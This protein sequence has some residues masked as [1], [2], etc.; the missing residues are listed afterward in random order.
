MELSSGLQGGVQGATLG[1]QVGGVHGAIIG[2]AIG[3]GLGLIQ[4]EQQQKAM[5]AYNREVVKNATKS[6]FDMRRLQNT[7]NIQTAQ[8]LSAYQDQF[9]TGKSTYN[10]AYGAADI[11]GSSADALTNTLRFQTQEATQQ[12][13]FNFDVGVQNYNANID[14]II[15]NATGQLG[16]K[17]PLN[18]Q[19]LASNLNQGLKL[20]SRYK[21]TNAP[22]PTEGLSASDFAVDSTP[23]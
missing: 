17:Q 4:G 13:W 1:A 20:Y 19:G 23:F 8:A 6:I 22:T 12:V 5:E 2:G 10:A 21:P 15:N 9:R 3:L 14:Q 7:Q 18:A 16:T 11:I